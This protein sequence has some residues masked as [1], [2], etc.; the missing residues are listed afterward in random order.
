MTAN[1]D[2]TPGEIRRR[3]ERLES[4]FD[5]L[6][7][8]KGVYEERTKHVELTLGDLEKW[9]DQHQEGHKWLSRLLA[10]TAITMLATLVSVL[11]QVA[12]GGG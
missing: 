6:V 1:G 11:I 8:P 9:H 10:G 3:I 5:R 2:F 4:D 12:G 7:V